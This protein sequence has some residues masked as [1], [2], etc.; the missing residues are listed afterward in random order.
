MDVPSLGTWEMLKGHVLVCLHC[1]CGDTLLGVRNPTWFH[2]QSLLIPFLVD[3]SVRWA[4]SN[5]L[6]VGEELIFMRKYIG[7]QNIS[8]HFLVFVGIYL[9]TY[10]IF[11]Y[12]RYAVKPDYL[13]L[14]FEMCLRYF[15]IL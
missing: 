6:I 10:Y 8:C 5:F 1:Y 14:I 15:F 4:M 13:N 7:Y 12:A 11:K 9:K 2:F 3:K